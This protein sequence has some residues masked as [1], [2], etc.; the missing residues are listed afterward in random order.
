MP[1]HFSNILVCCLVV[2]LSHNQKQAQAVRSLVHFLNSYFV[3]II[4]MVRIEHVHQLSPSSHW[5]LLWVFCVGSWFYVF[6]KSEPIVS[7]LVSNWR[8]VLPEMLRWRRQGYS[9]FLFCYPHGS[10]VKLLYF[11]SFSNAYIWWANNAVVISSLIYSF[12]LV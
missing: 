7:G 4:T 11:R 12:S 3:C 1:R 8:K 9:P 2:K 10:I 5:P 6:M